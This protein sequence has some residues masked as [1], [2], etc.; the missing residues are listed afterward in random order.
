MKALPKTTEELEEPSGVFRIIEVIGT[1]TV[2]FEDATKKRG[3]RA[4]ATLRHITGG[5]RVP[6]RAW[7]A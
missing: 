3:E 4:A 1:S 5:R 6:H 2:G 7:A